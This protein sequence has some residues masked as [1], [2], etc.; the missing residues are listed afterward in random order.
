MKKVGKPLGYRPFRYDLNQILYNYMVEA[1]NKFKALDLVDSMSEELWK[2]VYNFVQEAVTKTIPK[3]KKCEK[4]K[5]LSEEVLQ[6]VKKR[7]E[8]KS[9]GERERYIK[10]NTDFQRTAQRDKKAFFSEQ[11]IELE[12]NNRRRK[13][14]DLFRKVGDIKGAFCPK[15]S[16]IKDINYRDLVDAEEIKKRWKE[17]MEEL[18]KKDPNELDYFNGV[19]SHPEPDI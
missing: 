12:E 13:T 19:V 3:K 16:M 18:Y 8:V 1:M 7:R 6:T 4:A 11:C 15:M 14:R 17:Y 2:D 10:L 9:K 5:W